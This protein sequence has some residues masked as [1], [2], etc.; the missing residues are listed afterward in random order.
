MWECMWWKV[1]DEVRLLQVYLS[2]IH[3]YL[4]FLTCL[5]FRC[6][7][8]LGFRLWTACV[9]ACPGLCLMWDVCS[10]GLCLMWDVC[11]QGLCLM[12][13]G[14]SQGLC[15]MWDV[16]CQG[17]YLMWYV[18]VHFCALHKI[19]LSGKLLVVQVTNGQLFC[20]GLKEYFFGPGLCLREDVFGPSLCSREYIF[21][22]DLCL[23]HCPWSYLRSYVF[24]YRNV[25]GRIFCCCCCCRSM[26]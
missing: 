22:S 16:C 9:L 1:C 5:S 7:D 2:S 6:R 10:Q 17:L 24:V 4:L 11:S 12:W 3:Q 8:R 25:S 19:F 18:L 14:C 26:S 23:S 20:L 13:G 15:L 21:C